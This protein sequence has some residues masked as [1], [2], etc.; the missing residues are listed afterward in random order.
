MGSTD[1][2]THTANMKTII[3]AALLV[4]AACRP[5]QDDIDVFVVR[6]ESDPINGFNFRHVYEL[7][8]GVSQSV[9]GNSDGA[10]AAV[11]SGSYSVPLAEGGVGT[12]TYTADALGYRAESP[13][14]P[15]APVNPHPVPAH[16][17]EMINFVNAQLQAGHVWN[18]QAEAW[19]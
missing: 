10:G 4:V 18:Q 6:E 7:D 17:Q 15:V 12:V 11:I 1:D 13:V 8:N 9:V 14:L 19:V 5:Q 3:F 2:L 16:V